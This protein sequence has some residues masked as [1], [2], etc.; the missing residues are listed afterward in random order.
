M[1]NEMKEII[2]NNNFDELYHLGKFAYLGED[3]LAIP[4]SVYHNGKFITIHKSDVIKYYS[5]HPEALM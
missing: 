2:A 4:C 1:S 3:T 5:E